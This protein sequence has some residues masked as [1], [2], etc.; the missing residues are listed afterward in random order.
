MQWMNNKL[1]ILSFEIYK[2]KLIYEASKH[3]SY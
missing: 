1:K 2:I 3:N